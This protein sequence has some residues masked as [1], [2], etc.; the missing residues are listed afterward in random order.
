MSATSPDKI[1]KRFPTT[2]LIVLT[3]V[4]LV[5]RLFVTVSGMDFNTRGLPFFIQYLDIIDLK[6]NLL[7]GLWYFHVQ[8][9][10]F[11]LFLGSILQMFPEHSSV[12]FRSVYLGVG[13][14]M[15]LSVFFLMIRLRVEPRLA[16]VMAAIL[17]LSPDCLLFENSL[18]YTYPVTALLCISALF[19]HKF[20]ESFKVM[21]GLVFFLLI[22]VVVLTRSLFHLVWFVFWGL[23][24]LCAFR[25]DWKKVVISACIP[26]LLIVFWYGKNYVLFGSFSSSTIL[27]RN[28]SRMTVF[29]VP[30]DL[31][32]RLVQRGK[33]SGIALSGPFRP[34]ESYRGH[35]ERRPDTGI[36]IL[37]SNRRSNG[38]VNFNNLSQ[39]E[40]SRTFLR[41]SLY[42]TANLP[43]VYLQSLGRASLIFLLPASDSWHFRPIRK[44]LGWWVGIY[45]TVFH[46]RFRNPRLDELNIDDYFP[47]YDDLLRS[48]LSEPLSAPWFLIL[49]FGISLFYGAVLV[50]SSLK[51]RETSPEFA[52]TVLFLWGNIVYVTVVGSTCELYENNRFRFLVQPFILVMVGLFVDRLMCGRGEMESNTS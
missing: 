41:D 16:L 47:M 50:V 28:L 2:H 45:D 22:S 38:A 43:H 25:K 4:F 15:C 5:S 48:Y 44:N 52:F 36:P 26:M 3:I 46:G 27:G 18:L 12:A 13:F 23:V 34:L 51:N 24:L 10:L 29:K 8:P 31:R 7:T 32:V 14:A 49:Q 33:I 1:E 6:T 9:P 40:I 19:L 17:A 37:D 21:H 39:L 35:F 42:I 20:L 30:F 11:N